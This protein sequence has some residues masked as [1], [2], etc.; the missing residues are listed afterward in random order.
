MDE[1][2]SVIPQ[3]GD[4]KFL[5]GT[6]V[7]CAGRVKGFK[8]HPK[9]KDLDSVCLV[10]VI[11]TPHPM[12][13]S[14]Y[15]DHLWVLRRQLKGAGQVPEQNE[16][17][18]FSGNVYS[19]RRLGGKSLDRGLYGLEDYGVLPLKISQKHENRD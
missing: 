12:G 3:R 16:R 11:V 8:Q 17:I 14:I 6:L 18:H 19:Y 4:L 1:K 2:S 10:N 7:E 15:L 13:E 9:R 5:E